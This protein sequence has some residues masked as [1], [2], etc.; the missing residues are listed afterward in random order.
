MCSQNPQ[1]VSMKDLKITFPVGAG[2]ALKPASRGR[3]ETRIPEILEAAI[4]I[5]AAEGN[6]GF[7]QRRVAAASGVRL[8]T[9]Q[10]YFGTRDS[11]LL[12]TFQEMSKRVLERF[13]QL[14]SN[15]TVAPENRL[16]A[17]L[18]ETFETLTHTD[19]LFSRFAIECWSLAEHHDAIR[20]RIVEFSG[21][22]QRLF[23]DL[24]TQINPS[25]NV[26][27]SGI[28][29]ALIYSHWQGLIVFIR[30]SGRNCPDIDTFR[31]ATEIVWRALSTSA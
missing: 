28:R 8:A 31:N 2:D 29:G 23:G 19:S 30:R 7:T 11:L 1:L 25:L 3:R 15:E 18:D 6:A 17:V 27:E 26:Q 12:A 9:L 21:E 4:Q 5:F 24:V 10:H 13:R 22:F 16:K 14:A 20:E